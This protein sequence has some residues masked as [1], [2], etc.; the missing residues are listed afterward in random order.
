MVENA[1][2]TDSLTD[3]PLP[4][5]RPDP[6]G[7]ALLRLSTAVA[8]FGGLVL[9]ALTLMSV[10]G[11][12]ARQLATIP[13]L[14]QI[15]RMAGTFELVELGSA[16]AVSAFLPYCQMVRGNVAVDFFTATLHPRRRALL[17][18]AGNL[19]F[20]AIAGTLAWRTTLGGLDLRQ[21]HETTMVLRIPVWWAYVPL[22]VALAFLTLVCAYTTIRSLREAAGPGEPPPGAPSE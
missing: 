1:P 6:V 12:V 22:V 10:Y 17:S 9:A 4:G 11:I 16:V 20:T 18:A 19:L 13:G 8:V 14:S 7:R 15:G 21:Y 2:M 3:D 5:I